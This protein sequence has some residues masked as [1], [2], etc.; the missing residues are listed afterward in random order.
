MF[1]ILYLFYKN[2]SDNQTLKEKVE[3]TKLQALEIE[4]P[5]NG[6][7]VDVFL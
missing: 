2:H 6:N 1:G 5:Y 3:M 7:L 4:K